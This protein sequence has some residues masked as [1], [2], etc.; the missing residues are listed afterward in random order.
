[1]LDAEADAAFDA[2]SHE[3]DTP[4]AHVIEQTD[5]D[6]RPRSGRYA[7]ADTP[8]SLRHAAASYLFEW[9]A[10]SDARLTLRAL[11]GW[12]LTAQGAAAGGIAASTG[13]VG[14]GNGG[15]TSHNQE[16]AVAMRELVVWTCFED[17]AVLSRDS[18]LGWTQV[19]ASPFTLAPSAL[20]STSSLFI[21]DALLCTFLSAASHTPQPHLYTR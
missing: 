7:S 14:E 18:W 3:L 13:A 5:Q 4:P 17:A 12:P 16:D 15:S 1:M 9:F 20:P 2:D 11:A 8:H 6:S 10:S 21:S 19:C